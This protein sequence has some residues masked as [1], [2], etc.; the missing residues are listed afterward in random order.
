[1]LDFVFIFIQNCHRKLNIIQILRLQVLSLQD[2]NERLKRYVERLEKKEELCVCKLSLFEQLIKKDADIAFYTGI[3]NIT[4]FQ[5]LHTFIAPYVRRHLW[6]GAKV[7]STKIKR[8]FKSVPSRFGP[9]RKICGLDQFLLMWIK[10]RLNTPMRDL[11]VRFKVSA[12]TCSRIFSSWT[13]A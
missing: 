13:K 7:T 4:T 9:A 12:T 2:E 6:R 11:A 10:L 8:K 5:R 3:P 1:M